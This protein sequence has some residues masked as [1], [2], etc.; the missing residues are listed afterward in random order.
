MVY[1]PVSENLMAK[2]YHGL[3]FMGFISVCKTLQPSY[4]LEWC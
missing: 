1:I 4:V 2:E 3:M